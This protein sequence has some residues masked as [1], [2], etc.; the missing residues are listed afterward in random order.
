MYV[1]ICFRDLFSYV[2]NYKYSDTTVRNSEVIFYKLS[3]LEICI[4]VIHAQKLE[5]FCSMKL[6]S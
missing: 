1:Q 6:I 5:G 4:T 3:A 2:K